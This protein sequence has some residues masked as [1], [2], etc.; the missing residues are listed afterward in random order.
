[1]GIHTL[2]TKL[3]IILFVLIGSFQFSLKEVMAKTVYMPDGTVLTC[4]DYDD[5][6]RICY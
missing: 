5:G 3:I 1:M 4:W 6:S 2:S